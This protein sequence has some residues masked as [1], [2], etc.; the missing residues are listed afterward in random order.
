MPSPAF[1][2]R[3]SLSEPAQD[4]V[5]L[6]PATDGVFRWLLDGRAEPPARVQLPPGGPASV[7]ELGELWAE[8][9]RCR[10]CRTP[11]CWLIVWDGVAVGLIGYKNPPRKTRE[12]EIGYGV[13]APFRRRGVAK[14]AVAQLIAM[15]RRDPRLEALL[16]RT[17]YVNATS[18]RVLA[19]NGFT[20]I[21]TRLEPE[22]GAVR[23]WRKSLRE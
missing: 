8:A 20:R 22:E 7:E 12:V 17:A 9:R 3:N 1:R 13:A 14:R 4:L 15:A 21:E 11:A 2:L 19:A 5:A 6:A 10:D 18:E 16:A 23:V